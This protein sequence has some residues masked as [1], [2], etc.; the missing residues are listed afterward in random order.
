M[1]ESSL[2]RKQQKPFHLKST[3]IVC[4]TF[5]N[6]F[7]FQ[8]LNKHRNNHLVRGLGINQLQIG[9]SG[10]KESACQFKSPKRYGL[11][12]WVI[13]I[14]WRKNGSPLQYSCLGNPID[15]EACQATVHG[16]P[17]VGHNS[18]LNRRR[19]WHPTPVLLPGKSYR[20]RSLVGCRPWSR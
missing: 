20:R 1:I 2:R 6:L 16:V 18:V 11:N 15:R 19:Q 5:D 7:F 4:N 3:S 10:G 8:T 17:R 9:G 14:P 13:K 12:P